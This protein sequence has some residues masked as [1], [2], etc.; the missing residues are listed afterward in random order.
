MVSQDPIY[1]LFPVSV[2][3]IEESRNAD[4]RPGREV[5]ALI[6]IVVRLPDGS[7]YAHPG[8][9]NYTDPQVEQQTD[10]VTVRATL[11]N[12]E[13]LLIDGQFVTVQVRDRAPQQ[14]LVV[15]QA[16]LQADQAGDYVLVVGDDRKVE[17]RRVKT[18]AEQQSDIVIEQGLKEG[19]TVIVEG[20]QKVRPGQVV[21]TTPMVAK[22]G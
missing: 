15:P 1:V 18:G 4:R 12:P 16:A 13:R 8:V 17:L 3:Q 19:E 9:W 22:G 21:Q 20:M 10:T 6:E 7:E 2:R 5:A 14:R 11:P